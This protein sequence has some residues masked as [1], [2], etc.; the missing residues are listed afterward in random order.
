MSYGLQNYGHPIYV[1]VID[2]NQY[3]GNFE[4]EMGMYITGQALAY[5]GGGSAWYRE[6]A[7]KEL[8]P[9][10]DG[11]LPFEDR[12]MNFVGDD[13]EH[14]WPRYVYMVTDVNDEHNSV[15]LYFRERPPESVLKVVKE[16]AE[17][18]C[19]LVTP[20]EEPGK[21]FSG[22]PRDL[23]IQGYRLITI[24]QSWSSEPLFK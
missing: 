12:L 2:T 10:A 22:P 15:G 8:E 14:C 21:C 7:E 4:R 6:L 23:K 11:F 24:K 16:R 5:I 19:N 20:P 13:L 3:S 1:V 17:K 18:F 9:E